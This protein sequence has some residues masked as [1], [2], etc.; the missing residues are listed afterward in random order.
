MT[1]GLE[2]CGGASTGVQGH[3]VV[4]TGIYAAGRYLTLPVRYLLIIHT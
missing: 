2:V 3:A 1:K 4:T